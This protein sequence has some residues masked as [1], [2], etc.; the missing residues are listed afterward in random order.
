MSC[1]KAPVRMRKTGLAVGMAVA[2]ALT[3]CAGV[4]DRGKVHEGNALPVG[5]QDPDVQVRLIVHPPATGAK[6]EDVVAGFLVAAAGSQSDYAIARTYLTSSAARSWQPT[7]RAL[8]YDDSASN[9]VG[10][11][12]P[13][14][15]AR[16][17]PLRAPLLA[18]VSAD[19]D[20]TVATPGEAIHADF[21][22][23][24]EG[25]EWR[26]ANPPAGL[27]LTTLDL[28]RS[29]RPQAVYFLNRDLSLVVPNTVFMSA[30]PPGLATALM[31]ALLHGPTAWLA[32][33]VRTA[34]PAG[35]TLRSTVPVDDNGTATVDLSQQVL[36][37]TAS[38]RAQLSAQIVW[39]LRNVP[40]LTRVRLLADGNP[41]DVP[42]AGSTQ[43][44]DAWPTYDPAALTP[45]AQGYY[46]AGNRVMTVSGAHPPGLFGTS[47]S[48]LTDIALSPDLAF[49]AGLT[50]TGNR[51]TVYAGSLAAKPRAVYSA[52]A[53]FTAPSWDAS[54]ELWTVQ[55][56]PVPQVL[57][58]RPAAPVV[59]VP[60]PG[61]AGLAIREL[62]ISRDGTRVAVVARSG[63]GTELLVGRV[64]TTGD[65]ALRLDGFRVPDPTLGDVGHV[66]W[67]DANTVLLLGRGPGG[68]RIP[69]LV[70]VDGANP[71]PLSTSGLTSY[72]A[73]AGAPGQPVLAESGGEIYQAAH[74]LWT[75]VGRGREPAYPG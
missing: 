21:R 29:L 56:S 11:A 5:N 51:S 58:I 72:A 68:A 18:T 9:A 22:L 12:R 30:T 2:V 52:D 60:A 25:G 46:R 63:R 6:P 32:P 31:R 38:Q 57:V 53:A 42:T 26:I 34:I 17:V 16:V 61:L 10:S 62:R 13:S 4:P 49:A 65:G 33:A 37:S 36:D 41:F 69:W 8:V 24:R 50:H 74:G 15:A 47:P 64:S 28:S 75:P 48:V 43:S 7:A 45:S 20:Y 3:A 71:G 66:T 1:A 70:D 19:G 55:L 35:T 67:A 23:V 39:T 44:R 27:L 73:V 14:G 40:G 54:G 59:R